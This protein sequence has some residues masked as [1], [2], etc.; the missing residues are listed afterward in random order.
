MRQRLV[1]GNWKMNG[2][3]EANQTLLSCILQGLAQMTRVDCQVAVCPS[4]PY[5]A[6]VQQ[7]LQNS[8]V[9]WGAQDISTA[10]AGAYTGEVSANML[11]DFGCRWV[12]VGHSERRSYHGERSEIVADKA[13]RAVEHGI[14]PVI[15]VGESLAEREAN[16]TLA[17]IEKQL[18]P[19]LA[20]GKSTVL[21]TVVAYEPV[22][23]IGTGL[24]AT[25]T[26][27]Q[28]VHAFIRS[29]LASI[30]ADNIQILYGGSVK[31]DNAASLFAMPDIDGALVGG[32]ALKAS[33][34]LAI[35]TA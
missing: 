27:A 21:Q 32:A 35:I 5:L 24:T 9:T 20:L 10:E 23:A 19:V 7:C 31:A 34:F 11:K 12:I 1:M 33:E 16:Q 15:C 14:T 25:P 22:W 18:A 30:G 26:Q 17:V 4:F 29:Q 13:L 8:S 3:L 28:E 6:Q 2:S